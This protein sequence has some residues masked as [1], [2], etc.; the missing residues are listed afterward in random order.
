MVRSPRYSSDFASVCKQSD[1]HSGKMS[2]QIPGRANQN[3]GF[4]DNSPDITPCNHRPYETDDH[5]PC[6]VVLQRVYA[7]VVKAPCFGD[8]CFAV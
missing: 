3:P 1:D 7:I 2:S 4:V 8:L 5:D 6:D